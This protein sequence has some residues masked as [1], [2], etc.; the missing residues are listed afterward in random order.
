MRALCK[1]MEFTTV[2]I[3]YSMQWQ[4]VVHH[5]LALTEDTCRQLYDGIKDRRRPIHEKGNTQ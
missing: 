5:I 2:A 4:H 3:D 1:L